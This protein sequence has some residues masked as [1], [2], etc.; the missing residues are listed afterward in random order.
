MNNDLINKVIKDPSGN[1]WIL[2]FSD[3]IL[4]EVT[5]DGRVERYNIEE[6]T[7]NYPTLLALDEQGRLWC[8]FK[9]GAVVFN[10]DN[11]HHI[12]KFPKTDGDESI[13][14]IGKLERACGYRL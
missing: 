14:A 9:G 7:G 12:I 13:L 10:K 11:S 6:M 2:C 3:N 8:A 1:I 4:T 5:P